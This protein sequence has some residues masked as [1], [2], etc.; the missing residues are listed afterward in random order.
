MTE[1]DKQL[2]NKIVGSLIN[3]VMN[4]CEPHPILRMWFEKEYVKENYELDWDK[5]LDENLQWKNKSDME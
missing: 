5:R 4:V 2:V 3:T 1:T